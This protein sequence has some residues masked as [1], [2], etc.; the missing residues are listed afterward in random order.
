MSGQGSVSER[1]ESGGDKWHYWYGWGGDKTGGELRW[2]KAA[3]KQA[4]IEVDMRVGE[5]GDKEVRD[6]GKE[7]HRTGNKDGDCLH[8]RTNVISSCFLSR[9]FFFLIVQE[10]WYWK[11]WEWRK[12]LWWVMDTDPCWSKTKRNHI[13]LVILHSLNL[14]SEGKIWNSIDIKLKETRSIYILWRYFKLFKTFFCKP[15]VLNVSPC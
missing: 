12:M 6:V 8:L 10:T 5:M 9:F 13:W 7:S 1:W 4:E 15:K 11:T 3:E 2:S 14:T